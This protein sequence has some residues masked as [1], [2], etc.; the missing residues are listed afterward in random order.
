MT[1][2]LLIVG[3][4]IAFLFGAGYVLAPEHGKTMVKASK[5][6]SDAHTASIFALGLLIL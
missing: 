5:L 2:N 1:L 4:G 6:G 3:L